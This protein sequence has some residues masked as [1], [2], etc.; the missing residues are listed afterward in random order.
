MKPETIVVY[1]TPNRQSPEDCSVGKIV[2]CDSLYATIDT[3][4]GQTDVVPI[5]E[6]Q[7]A[8]DWIKAAWQFGGETRAN[9]SLR[10]N[11]NAEDRENI[12]YYH[13]NQEWDMMPGPDRDLARTAFYRGSK[14]EGWHHR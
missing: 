14:S 11:P 3:G 6:V 4:T 13:P 12:S 8:P 9:G 1:P 2:R 5:T 7:P 10:S